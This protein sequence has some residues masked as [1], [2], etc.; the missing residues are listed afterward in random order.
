VP[1]AIVGTRNRRPVPLR[2]ANEGGGLAE[3]L[4]RCAGTP[5]DESESDR[6]QDPNVYIL[7][8]SLIHN[9]PRAGV[10]EAVREL[11]LRDQRKIH[12]WAESDKRR[13]HLVEII[14]SLDVL[15]VVLVRVGRAGEPSERR[16]RKCMERLLSELCNAG[17][18]DVIFEAREDRQNLRDMY[19]L[20]V[21]R[22]RQAVTAE[23]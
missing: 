14:A 1:D 9:E 12:W 7:A 8:A 17:V 19:L 13:L 5:V 20:R 21:R 6:K 4:E 23:L 16:R 18:T 2:D 3:E 22:A 15:H 11:R 10:R